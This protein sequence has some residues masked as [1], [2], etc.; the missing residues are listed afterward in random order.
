MIVFDIDGTILPG[1]SCERLFVRY[2]I[3]R[4]I[5]Q[6]RHFINFCLRAP[7]LIHNGL[8]FITKANKGYLRNFSSRDMKA[9]GEDFFKSDVIPRISSKAKARIGD[10]L[11]SDARVILFSGMPDFLLSNFSELLGVSEYY[12]SLMEIK[13]ER[14]TGRTVGPFPLARGKIKALEMIIRGCYSAS[15]F[16]NSDKVTTIKNIV[17]INW[18]EITFYADHWL[19]RFL[20]S[21]VGHPIAVNPQEK[22]LE[23][24]QKNEWPI[25]YFN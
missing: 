13:G 1:T 15:N 24:A 3:K 9:I 5:L 21:K 10:H 6:P 2:L 17:S 16:N 14:L 8:P 7:A 18:T 11:K 4:K 20:L 23:L 22:L 25:E 12:G 19:D